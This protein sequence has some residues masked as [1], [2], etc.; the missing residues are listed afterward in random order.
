M[1]VEHIL[2]YVYEGVEEVSEFSQSYDMVVDEV[3]SFAVDQIICFSVFCCEDMIADNAHIRE[4]QVMK[5]PDECI[6]IAFDINQFHPFVYLLDDMI[7][8]VRLFVCPSSQEI[9]LPK[10]YEV[11]VDDQRFRLY[12][13]QEFQKMLCLRIRLAE[14]KIGDDHCS[15]FLFLHGSLLK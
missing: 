9:Q 4:M 11:A 7:H 1:L 10:I 3:E 8:Y 2:Y 14:M 12:A 6:V 15:V 13:F 5:L